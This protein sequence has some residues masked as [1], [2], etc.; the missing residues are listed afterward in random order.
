L[1]RFL[2]AT[3]SSLKARGRRS[4]RRGGA[5]FAPFSLSSCFA[6]ALW[7]EFS[8]STSGLWF[9]VFQQGP[10]FLPPS[11]RK[12]EAF[13]FSFAFGFPSQ[14]EGKRKNQRENS[15]QRP[16]VKRE[17]S[18]QKAKGKLKPKGK[19]KTQTQGR[20][21]GW[22]KEEAFPCVRSKKIGLLRLSLRRK[23]GAA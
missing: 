22:P 15:N 10:F 13:G 19:G 7:F 1:G 2:K 11:G 20:F 12:R 23:G 6:R 21:Q 14:R 4:N 3:P 18:N 16:L 8:L 9:S 17:N 5:C